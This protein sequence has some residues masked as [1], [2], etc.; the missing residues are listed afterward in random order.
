MAGQSNPYTPITF[1]AVLPLKNG[2]FT[3][4]MHT[5][6]WGWAYLR[7]K[8]TVNM[9]PLKSSLIKPSKS[10]LFFHIWNANFSVTPINSQMYMTNPPRP[11]QT[12]SSACWMS[13]T[14]RSK[15]TLTNSMEPFRRSMKKSAPG[16]PSQTSTPQLQATREH[17]R[18][19]LERTL[20][21]KTLRSRCTLLSLA[22]F[23]LARTPR[24]WSSY[25]Q[26][27]PHHWTQGHPR[28]EVLHHS[29][30]ASR[31]TGIGI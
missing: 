14:P 4:N 12:S 19:H 29:Q 23:C 9:P 16:R 31:T 30:S 7:K 5:I 13:P 10:M 17:R 11:N 18:T 1:S 26:L 27:P 21:A 22:A 8:I 3:V 25:S 24:L 28:K 20:K 2:I 6:K 15:L